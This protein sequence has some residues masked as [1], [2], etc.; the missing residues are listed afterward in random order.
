MSFISEAM[1]LGVMGSL[2]LGP[3][4][5]AKLTT[6]I[7]R[8]VRKMKAVQQELTIQ[9]QTELAEA[10]VRDPKLPQTVTPSQ[11]GL[12]VEHADPPA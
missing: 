9:F 1:V 6:D 2:V 8:I 3:K 11:G 7:T 4:R 12:R 5:V 10:E